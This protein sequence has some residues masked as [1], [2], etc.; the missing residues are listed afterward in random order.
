M[1]SSSCR[2]LFCLLIGVVVCLGP[3][4]TCQ[5]QKGGDI[6]KGLLR[7]LIESQLD[8]S[9]RR[10]AGRGGLA[11]GR[12]TPV[13]AQ[14][15]PQLR[16]LRPLT[17]SLNQETA[18]LVALL[19]SD[20]RRSVQARRRLPDAI[21]MQANAAALNQ[22]VTSQHNHVLLQDDFR[23]FNG[24]WGTLS[25][26]LGQCNALS[27]QTTAC[28]NRISQL[29]TQYC[30]ILGLQAQFNSEELI[31]DAYTL[32]TYNK[33]LIDHVR[34]RYRPGIAHTKL[35]RDLGTYAQ[36]GDYFASLVSRG[37]DY[38]TAVAT[39]QNCY[40]TWGKLEPRLTEYKSHSLTRTMR[41]IQDSNRS[42]HQLLRLEMGIDRNLVLHLIHTVDDELTQI[43]RS[44]TLED[45]ITMPDA[46]SL[47]SAAD[48]V[49]GTI[50]NLDDLAH[51]DQPV[52]DLAEAWVYADE[53]W[54]QFRYYARPLKNPTAAAGLRTI[55]D[56][57]RSL[58]Q[59]LGV[60]VEYDQDVLV[61][62]ASS[63][64]FQSGQL[65]GVVQRW[66]RRPG[67]HDRSLVASIQRMTEQFHGIEQS[68]E[69]G[70]GGLHHRKECDQAVPLWQKIRAVLRSCDT[71]E[72]IELDH[73]SAGITT[74]L[75][76]LRTMLD[77]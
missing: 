70:R 67:Q 3:G 59:T 49:F 2:K 32:T 73:L 15:T 23:G 17:A 6:V 7:G 30:S 76:K 54:K 52:Q 1:L 62:T 65:F 18:Q 26:N 44:I 13:P 24:D 72:R 36:Q 37:A 48:A 12:G 58:K 56:S 45:M 40:L 63:L 69:A 16:Q 14:V 75:L 74:G 31:R 39:F 21:R 64:E 28:I 38:Q 19:Q 57:M 11:P 33:D 9:R 5:A 4:S 35:L 41:R 20:A 25:H 61:Q 29:D 66:Q 53:A 34:D 55:T 27:P 8:K 60:T 42:I 68:L 43:Y 77:E 71:Q 51:R 22:R 50:Q 46:E 10:N 47:P